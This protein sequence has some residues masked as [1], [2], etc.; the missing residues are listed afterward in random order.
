MHTERFMNH[1]FISLLAMFFFVSCSTPKSENLCDTEN[2][3]FIPN[4]LFRFL[5][6]DKSYQC[7]YKLNSNP[8]ACELN[9]EETHLDA[10][11]PAVKKE[12]ESQFLLG[13]GPEESLI[14][15]RPEAI[16][17][18]ISSSYPAFQGALNAPNGNVYIV[19]YYSPKILE[20]DPINK[21]FSIMGT[22]SES[23]ERIG[24]ALGP[25][26][27]LYFA[28]HLVADFYAFDTN[29][30]SLSIL[31]NETM[32]G[33][34]YNGA[35]YAPNGKIYYVPST[36]TSIR[37]YDTNTK[38]IGQ[39]ATPTSGGFS[40]GVLT[41]Q[42]KIYFIPLVSTSMYI[43]DTKDDSVTTHP[44]V[45]PGGSAYISGILTPNG[46]I[47]MIPHSVAEILYLDLATNE[48]VLAGSV[49]SPGSSMFNGAVL[50]PNGKIYPIPENYSNFISFD[51]K[52]H[53]IKTLF[54]RP[55]GSYRGGALGP[56][57]EIYLAPHIA[58]RFDL[59]QTGS[60]GRFCQSLRLSPFW[61]KL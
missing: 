23:V 46:R 31:G 39:V 2:A 24:G 4:L 1:F 34:A 35:I 11:W 14:Q 52:D 44:Y 22:F 15:Y 13:S 57:G 20:V 51:T 55:A 8:P 56:D 47:Y 59:I 38:T 41:P 29:N 33:S 7:G 16:N 17:A 60:L 40:T 36:E 25:A 10:N 53:T 50:A 6:K 61:N 32:A 5:I 58:N 19:P 18:V 43:L 49:P 48:I 27:I 45:F 3:K 9:Y 37:Y 30:K 12:M 42:G 21:S 54:P 26:G 28:P